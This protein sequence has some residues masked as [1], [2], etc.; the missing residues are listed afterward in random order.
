MPEEELEVELVGVGLPEPELVDVDLFNSVREVSREPV[1]EAW[2]LLT[3]A[4]LP[5]LVLLERPDCVG[6]ELLL[7]KP[8]KEG[9]PEP[10]LV[11]VEL[12]VRLEWVEEELADPACEELADEVG[13]EP[14][15]R[16]EDE[17]LDVL[18]LVA[19]ECELVDRWLEVELP[20]LGSLE[21]LEAVGFELCERL[22]DCVIPVE[23][24]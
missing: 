15:G 22:S 7:L 16:A 6:A 19:A 9:L 18:D 17:I 3:E 10:E 2:V 11:S 14:L 20:W 24:A 13:F 8:A 21:D 1:E 23:P 4:E 12:P 5:E